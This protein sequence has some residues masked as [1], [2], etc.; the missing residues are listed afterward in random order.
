[1]NALINELKEKAGLTEEQA[2]KACE[3]ALN[4]VKAKLPAG[5]AD[6]LDGLLNGNIDL[7]NIFG[8]GNSDNESGSSFDALKGMFGGK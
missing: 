1:M 4:F 8:G 5:F 6:K 7:G 3:T 2:Q